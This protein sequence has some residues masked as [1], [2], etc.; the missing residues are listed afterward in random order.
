[1]SRHRRALPLAIFGL[2][3]SCALAQLTP[4]AQSELQKASELAARGDFLRAGKALAALATSFPNEAQVRYQLGLV[5]MRQRKADAAAEH[6]EAA[7]KLD[8]SS[9]LIWLAVAQA[10]LVK[11][12]RK[13]AEEAA[14]RADSLSPNEPLVW[15]ALSMFYAQAGDFA[16]AAKYESQWTR[17]APEDR[18]APLRA[19]EYYLQAGMPDPA[20]AMARPSAKDDN[21]ADAW[22]ILGEAYRLKRDPAKAVEAFQQATRLDPGEPRYVAGLAQLFLDHNTPT[23]AVML[24]EEA[25]LRFDKDAD[26]VRMLGLACYATGDAERALDQFLKAID[27]EPESPIGYAALET[28]IPEAGAR[29]DLVA[30]KV[31]SF[32]ARHPSSPLGHYLLALALAAQGQAPEQIES[33]LRKAIA[34]DAAFWPAWFELHKPLRASGRIKE[35]AAALEKTLALKPD[36]APARYSLAQVYASLGDTAKA[37]EQ[38]KLHHRLMLEERQETERRQREMPKLSYDVR[39]R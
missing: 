16:A 23:P 26:L 32:A 20:I 30:R 35:A 1:M 31:Q 19:A 6:L 39:A 14:S 15:R 10:R 22:R 2:L 29:L 24:L 8:P 13:G 11:A 38:R 25:V 33:L 7:A 28:L 3:A 36:L 21:G 17:A 34:A 4:E 12:D 18:Q 37:V 9:A 5:L 27:L